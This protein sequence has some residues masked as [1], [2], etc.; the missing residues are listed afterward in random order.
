MYPYF[1]LLKVGAST[2]FRPPLALGEVS[3]IKMR[4]WLGD[5]DF[6]PELNNGR[7]LALMDMGRL[8]FAARSGFLRTAT[9][10]KWT[11]AVAGISVRYRRRLLPLR[12]FILKT[13]LIG[14]DERWFYFHQRTEREGKVCSSALVRVALTSKKG[15]VP[16]EEALQAT[17]ASD[18]QPILPDWVQAWIEAEKVRP[19]I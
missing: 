5:L 8:D 4:V 19:V 6:Y 11:L 13:E 9:Q 7:H 3:E 15:L 18:W 12:S 16:V 17:D 1:R 14:Y 2:F 10:K